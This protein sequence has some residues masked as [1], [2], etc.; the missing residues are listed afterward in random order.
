MARD[1]AVKYVDPVARQIDEENKI[2]EEVIKMMGELELFG[3]PF[4]E[5]Y[6][7]AEGG[8]DG[9]TLVMEQIAR[10][11]GGLGMTLAAHTL[12]LGAI[13]KFGTEEQKKKY[14]PPACKAEHIASFAFTEPATGSDPKQITTTA[15]REGDVYILNGTKRFISNANYPGPCIIFAR[16]TE[17]GEITAF[18]VEKYCEGYSISE[19]WDKMCMHGGMLL[20]VYLKDVKVPTENLLGKL[21]QGFPILLLGIAL[22]KIGTST[23]ALGGTLAAYEEAIKYAKEKTHRGQP[24]AKFQAMQLRIANL[25]I[26]YETSRWLCYRL[27]CLANNIKDPGEF[28]R[29]AALCKAYCG[30]AGVDAARIAMD[31]H[32]S[33]GVMND[34]TVSRIYRDA[35]LGPQIEGVSDMQK[36]IVAGGVLKG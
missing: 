32:G 9:Y 30:D 1:F 3:V 29:E 22:G 8:Y 12:G 23:C 26:L 5:E 28:A 15:A 18:I 16:E 35:I 21:G 4:A 33:Y 11:S 20:D 36:M 34:Y 10:V 7:G 6:G 24:I 31:V 17:S 19:P 14:M 13:D 25:A 27:G 2:P